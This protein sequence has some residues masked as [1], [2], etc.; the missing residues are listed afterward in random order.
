M[1]D[2]DS[3]RLGLVHAVADLLLMFHRRTQSLAKRFGT[4][5]GLLHSFILAE[6]EQ[7]PGISSSELVLRLNV[8]KSAM[9]RAI[10]Q[11]EELGCLERRAD[12]LDRRRQVL[13]LTA[14]GALRLREDDTLRYASHAACFEDLEGGEQIELCSLLHLMADGLGAANFELRPGEHLMRAV[15]RRLTV[16]LGFFARRFMG[17]ETSVL[18]LHILQ[19]LRMTEGVAAPFSALCEKLPSDGS[20]ISRAAQSLIEAGAVKKRAD[21]RDARK[22]D[23]SMTKEGLEM[24]DSVFASMRQALDKAIGSLDP[25]VLER[26]TALMS[27]FIGTVPERAP[28]KEHRAAPGEIA[29]EPARSVFALGSDGRILAVGKFEPA[30]GRWSLASYTSTSEEPAV[31]GKLEFLRFLEKAS[32][33]SLA[34]EVGAS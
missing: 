26:M 30:D 13:T 31:P 21:P 28:S 3:A 1:S 2:Q 25:A 16:Q 17:T 11:L 15:M 12:K 7:R 10:A 9:S 4:R 5:L 19:V 6:I 27:K 23:V 33:E 22:I 8:E 20:S 32:R 14:A 18:Q 29:G 34:A 24:H